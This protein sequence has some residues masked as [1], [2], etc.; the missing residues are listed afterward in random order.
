MIPAGYMYKTI[1]KKPDWL[2][3]DQVSDIYSVSSCMSEDFADWIKYWKHNG[4]WLFDSPAII[5]AIAHEHNISLYGMKLFFY[6][7]Y[8]QQWETDAKKWK[9][10]RPEDSLLTHVILPQQSK[11]EGYDIVSFSCQNS[12]ECSPLSC[13]RM[14]QAIKVNP[15]CLLDSFEGAKLLLEGDAFKDCEPGPYRIYEV[16]T[17]ENT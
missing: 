17:I 4:H 10:Y 14:A 1:M 6:S 8:E 3:S 5:K 13:N 11:P 7:I 16:H 12:A 9:P 2:E 15:H